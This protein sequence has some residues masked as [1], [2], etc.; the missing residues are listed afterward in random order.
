VL[1]SFV[2]VVGLTLLF[3]ALTNR[4]LLRV[5]RGTPMRNYFVVSCKNFSRESCNWSPFN[6]CNLQIQDLTGCIL[7]EGGTESATLSRLERIA[8]CANSSRK[9][10]P[11]GSP[12]DIFRRLPNGDPPWI[13]EIKGLEEAKSGCIAWLKCPPGNNSF[14]RREEEECSNALPAPKNGPRSSDRS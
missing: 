13:A 5:R 10:A 9:G 7:R 4:A 6:G 11:I 3:R 8:N 1:R 12:F 14:T 2:T